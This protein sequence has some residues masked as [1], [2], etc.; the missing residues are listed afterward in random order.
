MTYVRTIDLLGL[1]IGPLAGT[2]KVAAHCLLLDSN[3][4][5]QLQNLSRRLHFY[6]CP[7][8]FVVAIALFDMSHEL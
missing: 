1:R 5:D 4:L 7:V 8:N 6:I 2:G 3:Y